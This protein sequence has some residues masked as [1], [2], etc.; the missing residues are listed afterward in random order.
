MSISE[1][2]EAEARTKA[3]RKTIRQLLGSKRFA[4]AEYNHIR[5]CLSLWQSFALIN[6]RGLVE[7]IYDDATQAKKDL[8]ET[9]DRLSFEVE[10]HEKLPDCHIIAWKWPVQLDAG[11]DRSIYVHPDIWVKSPD[12]YPT[13]TANTDR[14]MLASNVDPTDARF[15]VYC[16]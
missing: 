13:V 11:K 10:G 12:D 2:L 9:I 8:K 6:H 15:E 1:M 16:P 3:K 7:S 5:L 4:E 14:F